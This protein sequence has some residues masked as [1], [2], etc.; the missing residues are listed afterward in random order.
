MKLF[1]MLNKRKP[2]ATGPMKWDRDFVPTALPWHQ[3]FDRVKVICKENQLRE[4]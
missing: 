2:Q 1:N 3:I 4:F